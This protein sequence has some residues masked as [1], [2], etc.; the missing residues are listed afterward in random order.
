ML[1]LIFSKRPIRL[2]FPNLH[3]RAVCF[4]FHR[5]VGRLCSFLYLTELCQASWD[6]SEA[7]YSMQKYQRGCQKK[8]LLL[9]F[10]KKKHLSSIAEQDNMKG[11]F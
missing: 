4:C 3:V 11:I 7:C 6:M 8:M 5:L 1:F 9:K 10:R 2:F